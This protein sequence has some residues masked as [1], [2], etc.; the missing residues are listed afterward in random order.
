MLDYKNI[1]L[2]KTE[3]KK[4]INCKKTEPVNIETPIKYTIYDSI[5]DEFHLKYNE[6][7]NNIELEFKK[8]LEDNSIPFY[9]KNI[10]DKL[11][12]YKFIKDNCEEFTKLNNTIIEINNANENESDNLSDD[13]NETEYTHTYKKY[14]I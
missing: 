3:N 1:L 14:S 13:D 6:T 8:F 4:D 12:I 2:T 11:D 10:N 7:I 9:D 5:D